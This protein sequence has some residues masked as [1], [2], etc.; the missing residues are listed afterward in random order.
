MK[1][2]E[3]CLFHGTGIFDVFMIYGS[4]AGYR[5]NEKQQIAQHKAKEYA[6][7]IVTLKPFY[8]S[9]SFLS[10]VVSTFNSIE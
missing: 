6:A 3:R 1:W 10:P 2:N 9:L 4:S 5:R 8:W 7:T